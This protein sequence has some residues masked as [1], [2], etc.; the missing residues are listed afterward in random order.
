MASRKGK[1][2]ISNMKNCSSNAEGYVVLGRLFGRCI[3]AFAKVPLR[4]SK[5][6]FRS[7]MFLMNLALNYKEPFGNAC[8]A[9]TKRKMG[10]LDAEL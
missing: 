9:F 6:V 3:T 2:T 1:M 10:F 4:S 8:F 5:C 7:F